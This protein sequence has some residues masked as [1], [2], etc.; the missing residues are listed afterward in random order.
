MVFW[1]LAMGF[2]LIGVSIA[3]YLSWAPAF[4]MRVHGWSIARVGA[5]YGGIL[6]V[7]STSGILLGGWWVDRLRPR[8]FKDAVLKVAV[9][10]SVLAL[11]FAIGAPFA[12]TGEMAMA[13]IAVMSFAF[14]LSQGLPA[15]AFQAVAPNRVRARVI[16]LYLLVGN[17]IGFTVVRPAWR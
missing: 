12:P 13:I 8:G 2:S 9:A 16:A 1:L 15:A 7:F 3:A 6:L 14:G 11:P 10:G 17:I 4:M 5:V